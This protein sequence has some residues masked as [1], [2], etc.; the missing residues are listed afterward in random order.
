MIRTL[1]PRSR[2]AQRTGAAAV[3]V[4]ACAVLL[5]S[6]AYA[7]TTVISAPP[8][9]VRDALLRPAPSTRLLPVDTGRLDTSPWT[10]TPPILDASTKPQLGPGIPPKRAPAGSAAAGR[11]RLGR[12]IAWGILGAVGGFFAGGMVGAALEG[13]SCGCDD[14]GLMGFLVGAPFGAA[15]GGI[16][17]AILAR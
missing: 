4:L 13:D 12:Q 9:K 1:A 10:M 8:G 15:A 11:N 7:Q 16:T 17:G 14:P 6:S 5:D 3:L 2:R